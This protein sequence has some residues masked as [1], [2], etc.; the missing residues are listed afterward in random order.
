LRSVERLPARA[1]VDHVR[2]A[3]LVRDDEVD[4]LARLVVV[5]DQPLEVR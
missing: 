4:A 1:G 2:H 5:V 3:Q